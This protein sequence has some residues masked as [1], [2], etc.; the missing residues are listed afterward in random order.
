MNKWDAEVDLSSWLARHS[1][2]LVDPI[3]TKMT[4]YLKN[5]LGVKKIGALGTEER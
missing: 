4:S 3:V 1:T 2:N 5:E